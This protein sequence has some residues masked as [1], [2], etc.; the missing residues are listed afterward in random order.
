MSIVNSAKSLAVS[1][2]RRA[3]DIANI[4][5]ALAKA[6]VRKPPPVHGGPRVR[7][8]PW[9]KRRHFDKREKRAVI[10]LLNR[11][12]RKGGV[13]AYGGAE[14]NA[15]CE[16]FAKYLGGGFADAVNSGTNAVYVALRALDLEPNT[17]VIV[18][19]ITDAGGTMPV[20]MANCIPNSCRL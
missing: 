6:V 15:Y 8:W 1:V 10:D 2:A 5:P 16:A 4:E 12:I 7:R 17:E 11:E 13:V 14:E 18:P 9:P 20:V 19:P 3:L